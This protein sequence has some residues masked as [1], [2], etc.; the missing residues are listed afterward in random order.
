M[1]KSNQVFG[2]RSAGAPEWRA[3]FYLKTFVFPTNFN[4]LR[5]IFRAGAPAYFGTLRHLGREKWRL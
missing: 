5:A 3:L 2:N 1:V 4:D